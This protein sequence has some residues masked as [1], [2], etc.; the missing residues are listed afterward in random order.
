MLTM[1]SELAATEKGGAADDEWTF[2][3]N[4]AKKGLVG[5]IEYLMAEKVMVVVLLGSV[6]MSS[7]GRDCVDGEVTLTIVEYVRGVVDVSNAWRWC[8]PKINR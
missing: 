5:S 1:A 6:R 8:R 4:S 3:W 7:V 2:S